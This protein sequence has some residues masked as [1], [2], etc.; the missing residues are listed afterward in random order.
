MKEA[1]IMA[2]QAKDNGDYG[3]GA[4][5]VK[6]GV[7]VVR[8]ANSTKTREDPTQHAELLAISQASKILESRHLTECVLY[9]THEPCPMCAAAAVWAK[10]EGIVWGARM[11]DMADYANKNGNSHYQWR[12]I[13]LKAQEIIEKGPDQPWVIDDFMRDECKKL[14][15]DTIIVRSL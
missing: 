8:V 5:I 15:H 13:K 10:L 6:N 3:I 11:E 2:H 4:V 9:T 14:F 7:I 1:I 12:T